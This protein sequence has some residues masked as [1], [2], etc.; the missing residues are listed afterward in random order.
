MGKAECVE[1][2]DVHISC[3]RVP[4]VILIRTSSLDEAQNF[5]LQAHVFTKSK[6]DWIHLNDNIPSF[7]INMTETSCGLR[8]V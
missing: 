2:K 7:E 4:G 6:M 8:Q 5:P 3:Q 1:P